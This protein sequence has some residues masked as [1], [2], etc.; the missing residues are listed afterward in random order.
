MF[1]KEHVNLIS[2]IKLSLEMHKEYVKD[3]NNFKELELMV[4]DVKKRHVI[5]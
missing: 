2:V 1:K 3:V 5:N 4:K